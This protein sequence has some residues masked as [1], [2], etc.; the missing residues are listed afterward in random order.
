MNALSQ[1]KAWHMAILRLD[2]T[3]TIIWFVLW[4]FVLV[5]E[6][7]QLFNEGWFV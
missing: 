1:M 3:L 7:L 6:V 4:I 5:F 2:K